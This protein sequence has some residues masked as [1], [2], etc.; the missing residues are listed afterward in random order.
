MKLE[1]ST[2]TKRFKVVYTGKFDDYPGNG[3]RLLG[4]GW[5]EAD[6]LN[7]MLNIEAGDEVEIIA[8]IISRR[9]TKQ[10][11]IE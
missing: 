11:K 8:K 3:L 6:F 10:E 1:K 5:Y 9:V 4:G 7:D 2:A